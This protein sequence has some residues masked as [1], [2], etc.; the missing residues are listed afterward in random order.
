M[1]SVKPAYEQLKFIFSYHMYSNKLFKTNLTTQTEVT[2]NY[3]YSNRNIHLCEIS[4]GNLLLMLEREK[5]VVSIDSLREFAVSH[6]PPMLFAR[7]DLCSVYYARHLYLLGGFEG[8]VWERSEVSICERYV[9]DTRRWESLEPLPIP[10]AVVCAIEAEGS[11]YALGGNTRRT[12]LDV[13]QAMNLEILTWR[14]MEVRLPY[15]CLHFPCFKSGDNEVYFIMRK[16]LYSFLPNE[17]RI[18]KVKTLPDDISSFA[19]T[20]Y[21][22]Q[23]TLYCSSRS[24]PTDKW[25]IKGLS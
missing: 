10:C 4:G 25:L 24:G 6:L 14:V 17:Q 9:C 23:G 16:T 7:T 11:L 1:T 20:T 18:D 22:S 15:L 3:L 13:I 19:G 5:E 8:S 12:S 21:Y 2:H